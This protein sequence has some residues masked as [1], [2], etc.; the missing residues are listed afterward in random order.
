MPLYS[1]FDALAIALGFGF[2]PLAKI[3]AVGMGWNCKFC[4]ET[5]EQEISRLRAN[6]KRK[7][8]IQK[9]KKERERPRLTKEKGPSSF[10][11]PES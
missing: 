7:A 9:K 11:V 10:R 3:G 2:S 8:P 5:M 4:K 6:R 1:S